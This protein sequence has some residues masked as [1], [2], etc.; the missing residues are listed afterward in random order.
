MIFFSIA[1]IA[2]DKKKA[3]KGPYKTSEKGW[4]YLKMS[5]SPHIPNVH[6][7]LDYIANDTAYVNWYSNGAFVGYQI[8]L[9]DD[10]INVLDGERVVKRIGYNTELGKALMK[11]NE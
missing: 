10:S 11:D 4:Y 6:P 8:E 5:D 2:T 3:M 9:K 1:G 7:E